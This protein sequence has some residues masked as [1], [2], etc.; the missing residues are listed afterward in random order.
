MATR[1]DMPR[2][3]EADEMR[4]VL[5]EVAI[6]YLR[7]YTIPDEREKILKA[8]FKEWLDARFGGVYLSLQ[9]VV[10]FIFCY[11][12]YLYISSPPPTK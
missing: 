1:A 2:N 12:V 4:K 8:V 9:A 10:A 5:R 11:L 6:E 3:K 7:K